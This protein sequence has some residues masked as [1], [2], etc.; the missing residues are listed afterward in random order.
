MVALMINSP[1]DETPYETL[2]VDPTASS[3]ELNRAYR[4]MARKT[5]PDTGGQVADFQRVQAAW[6][7][8]GD[9]RSREHYD[10]LHRY[11][12]PYSPDAPPA[13]GSRV[14]STGAARSRSGHTPHARSF[15]HPGG[16]AREKY[17][18]LMDEWLGRGHGV[19]DLYDPALVRAAP[20]EIRQL[21]ADALA[22]EATARILG[23]MGLGFTVW[24]GVA[25]LA[26]EAPALDHVVLSPAGLFALRSADWGCTVKLV[27]GELVGAELP[28]GSTPLRVFARRAKTWSRYTGV[29]FSEMIVVVPDDAFDTDCELIPHGRHASTSV[30]RRSALPIILRNGARNAGRESIDRSFDIRTR[31]AETVRFV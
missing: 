3:E 21:L 12:S 27:R 13:T 24:N 9:P 14:S 8:V 31:I 18:L 7:L 19:T 16:A 22:Q 6:E 30:V 1:H 29:R 15:G 23:E 25:P 11:S 10:R 26:P 4:T 2:G 28:E 20:R 17:L 5:H